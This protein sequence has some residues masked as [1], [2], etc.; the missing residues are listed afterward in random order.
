MPV[1]SPIAMWEAILGPIEAAR[2]QA[3]A[4][5]LWWVCAASSILER[6]AGIGPLWGPYD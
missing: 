1:L 4:C 2:G 3:Y 6:A 5:S